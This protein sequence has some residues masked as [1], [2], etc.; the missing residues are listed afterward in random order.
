VPATPA[1][2][3]DYAGF[4]IRLAAALIDLVV[5]SV[6]FLTLRFIHFGFPFLFSSIFIPWLY[7]WLFTG[8]KGQTPGKM[9]VGIKVV[10]AR[11]SIPGLGTAALREIPGKLVSSVVF[12]LG[13][14][15]IIWDIKKQGWHDKVA[16]TYVVRANPK[17]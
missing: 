14:L 1:A 12:C 4:W 15:W 6:V 8:L 10:N 2:V 11:G 13:Y 5:I 3:T 7:Y 9:A 16:G 17:R